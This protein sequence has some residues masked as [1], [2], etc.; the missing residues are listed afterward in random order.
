MVDIARRCAGVLISSRHVLTAAHCV[1]NSLQ[2]VVLGEHDLTT[3]HDCLDPDEGCEAG[4][5]QCEADHRCAPPSEVVE[6]WKTSIHPRYRTV[7]G[8]AEFDVAIITLRRR[9]EFSQYIHPICLPSTQARTLF[10]IIERRLSYWQAEDY[11]RRPV[12]VLGWGTETTSFLSNKLS[13]TLKK[14]E[15][16]QVPLWNCNQ[17]YKSF[18][19]TDLK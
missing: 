10:S 6:V 5:A 3:T 11:H 19:Y 7:Q 1:K 8:F 18:A 2:D 14:L 13:N 9:L 17:I 16:S 12:T 4:G 15:L